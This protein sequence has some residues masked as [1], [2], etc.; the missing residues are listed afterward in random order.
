LIDHVAGLRRVLTE[1]TTPGFEVA[2]E[3][4]TAI[5]EGGPSI[6]IRDVGPKRV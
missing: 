3:T 2:E 5:I 6:E 4:W 1:S